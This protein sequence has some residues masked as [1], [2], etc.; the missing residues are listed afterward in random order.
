M[1]V[2]TNKATCALHAIKLIR[3]YFNKDEILNL[4]TAIFFSILYYNSE[5]W[6]IPKLKHELKQILLSSSAN[7]V[8]LAQNRPNRCESFID[9]HKSCNKALPN[10]IINY[11]HAILLHKSYNSFC[12]SMDWIE[13]NFTQ[14][15]TSRQSYFNSIKSS[16]YKVGENL[17]STRLS[18][19]NHKIP[20]NDLNLSLDSFKVKYKSVFL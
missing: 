6:H 4:L 17:I 9:V 19:L 5:V 18:I 7:A 20:L 12:P 16:N 15:F 10:Q 13:L 1:A 2:Q 14:T 8:K 3:K 11:K